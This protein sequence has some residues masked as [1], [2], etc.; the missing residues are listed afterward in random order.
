MATAHFP[1]TTATATY[2][3]LAGGSPVVH[4]LA[5]P[6]RDIEP[7]DARTRFESWSAD[8]TAREVVVV[9]AGVRDIVGSIRYDDQPAELKA[10]IRE[11]WEHDVVIA[12]Q[13]MT[14][15]P[16][17]QLRIVEVVGGHGVAG[18]IPD[19]DRFAFGEYEARL[20][21]RLAGSG[22]LDGLL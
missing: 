21:L 16:I 12:Y 15:G 11:G 5:V 13:E 20:R 6:I 18:V 8:L 1:G 4:K 2:T 19:R 10:L 9:G 14:A 3:P 17:Y 22:T 7:L